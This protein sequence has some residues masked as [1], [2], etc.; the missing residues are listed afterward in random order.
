M[1]SVLAPSASPADFSRLAEALDA[2]FAKLK[3]ATNE[4]LDK[5]RMRSFQ[6]SEVAELTGLS[7][8]QIRSWRQSHQKEIES[9]ASGPPYPLTLSEIHALM[10]DFGVLPGRPDG[11]RAIRLGV[12]GFKGGVQK[13]STAFHLSVYFAMRGYR[14]LVVDS[15]PQG[16]LTSLFGVDGS[17]L[18][19]NATL[20]AALRSVQSQE[21]YDSVQLQPLHTHI[22][23]LDLIPANLYMAGADIAIAYAFAGKTELPKRFFSVVDRAIT[24]VEDDYDIVLIDGAPSFSFGSLAILWACD[25][26]VIPVPPALPDVKATGCFMEMFGDSMASLCSHAGMPDRVWQP[27]TVLHGRTPASSSAVYMRK[28]CARVLGSMLLEDVIP[29]TSAVPNAL[30]RFRSVFEVTS[31]EVDSRALRKAREAYAA[32]GQRLIDAIET[33]WKSGK[34]GGEA[35]P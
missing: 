24:T 26:F 22:D 8:N 15:D 12:V 35:S 4:P 2:T 31:A 28:M 30:A 17:T 25:G 9:A 6:S 34:L 29:D 5:R 33:T 16:T 10:A 11:A 21:A 3:T 7:V 1:D 20:S 23:R 13:S 14:V 32:V 27:V 18:D 19:D